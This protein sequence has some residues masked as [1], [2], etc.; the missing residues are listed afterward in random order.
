MAHAG[1]N[2]AGPNWLPRWPGWPDSGTRLA[3][4]HLKMPKRYGFV[5]VGLDWDGWLRFVSELD[6]VL[7]RA[8]TLA[9]QRGSTGSV[10]VVVEDREGGQT[11]E[12]APAG[13][14]R[15][16][17]SRMVHCNSFLFLLVSGGRR[18]Q[19][20]VTE[21]LMWRGKWL[22]MI[23][24]ERGGWCGAEFELGRPLYIAATGCR[25]RSLMTTVRMGLQASSSVG[26]DRAVLRAVQGAS[27][28]WLNSG[29][30]SSTGSAVRCRS[31]PMTDVVVLHG[32]SGSRAHMGACPRGSWR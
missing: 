31:S 6:T 9:G 2:W 30:W 12:E 14:W 28:C 5:A 32:G 19:I 11:D 13:R 26:E 1:A 27:R 21:G 29:R 15:G 10:P 24:G 16:A 18:L 4:A 7:R 22:R 3:V 25:G 17:A 23:E 20:P 8:G